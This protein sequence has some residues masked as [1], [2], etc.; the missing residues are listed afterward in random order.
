MQERSRS[1][2]GQWRY[3]VFCKRE[4]GDQAF[5]NRHSAAN[6]PPCREVAS[7]N[8]FRQFFGLKQH[9]SFESINPDREIADLLRKLYDSPDMVELYP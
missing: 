6:G 9:D 5:H 1:T 4:D 7:L 3:W 8:E 2:Y